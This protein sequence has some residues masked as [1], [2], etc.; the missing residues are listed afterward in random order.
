MAELIVETWPVRFSTRRLTI[1]ELGEDDRD[2]LIDLCTSAQARRYLGGPVPR[3]H[4]EEEI[5]GASS[6]IP[7]SFGVHEKATGF[8]VG[9][10]D[11]DRRDSGR[12][13][14][15]STKG[16]ELEVSYVLLPDHWG[17]GYAE[18]AVRSVL[19]W[20]ASTLPDLRVIAVTQAANERSVALL[21][22][23]GFGE[24]RRFQEFGAEQTLR[25]ADLATFAR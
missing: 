4:A 17:K 14:H 1:R 9:T 20:A 18:E 25:V 15:I 24:V 2:G 21:G 8:F 7:G 22:R 11:L 23:L 12:P 10:V 13:G 5:A 6:E 16:G 19:G 3:G